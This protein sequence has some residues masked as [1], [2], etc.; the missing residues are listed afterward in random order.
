MGLRLDTETVNKV[1]GKGP[2]PEL[3]VAFGEVLPRVMSIVWD[4]GH[5]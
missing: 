2:Y 4:V 5:H 3:V 1:S